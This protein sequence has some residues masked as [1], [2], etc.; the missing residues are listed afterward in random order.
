[1]AT[2]LPVHRRFEWVNTPCRGVVPGRS[3]QGCW[4]LK[5]S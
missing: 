3:G 1:V 4:A 2:E 5:A